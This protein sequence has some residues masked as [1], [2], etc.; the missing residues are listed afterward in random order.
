MTISDLQVLPASEPVLYQAL[1]NRDTRYDGSVYYG[2]TSTGIFCRPICTARK[3]KPENVHYFS[4]AK[5]ALDA[6]FRPCK[7]CQPLDAVGAVPEQYHDLIR[8][9][10]NGEDARIRDADLRIA[11]YEPET[12]RRWF[13]RTYGV[14]FQAFARSTRL[15]KAFDSIRCGSSITTA[16]FESGY[17]SMSGFADATRNITGK[18]P[19]RAAQDGIL[20][21][22]RFDTPLGTM[23]AGDY[24]GALCL[25]E[26]ADRRALEK[27]ITDLERIFRVPSQ[28]GRTSLHE[29]VVQ[30]ISEY[31]KGSRKTFDIPLN[32]PGS[33]FTRAVWNGLQQ[34]PYGETRSYREQAERIGNPTAYR[35]VARANGANRVSIIVPCHRVIG[36]DGSL[37]GYGGG[38]YRKRALLDL[39]TNLRTF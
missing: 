28:P 22:T 30:E 6:G 12:V 27:E 39:E 3:P 18:N 35:A 38:L 26:F 36:S 16:T 17:G 29:H 7:I 33:E 21:I 2:I 23:V 32:L 1:I 5:A 20:W 34:I 14:T 25:L 19:T 37:T 11:G 10:L 8:T 13:K 15:A 24:L 4:S 9:V 31:Y